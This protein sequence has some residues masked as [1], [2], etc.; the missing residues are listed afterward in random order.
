[1]RDVIKTLF[2]LLVFFMTPTG[3][4]RLVL[5]ETQPQ[6]VVREVSKTVYVPKVEF[7]FVTQL[8]SEVAHFQV[9][10]D[11]P[12]IAAYETPAPDFQPDVPVWTKYGSGVN[13]LK[14]EVLRPKGVA[15]TEPYEGFI[16]LQVK[17]YFDKENLTHEQYVVYGAIKG[18]TV[19]L[20][21]GHGLPTEFTF[22]T[23]K[24]TRISPSANHL[25]FVGIT[26][27]NAA[28]LHKWPTEPVEYDC[29]VR[30]PEF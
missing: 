26:K 23:F 4:T 22:R 7:R 20:L 2:V 9:Q 14:P 27:L 13:I 16:R 12:H 18:N 6:V 30:P 15:Y 17:D 24:C 1:M 8:F 3:C 19:L 28:D 29:Y 10:E 5:E 25:P 21:R 11:G